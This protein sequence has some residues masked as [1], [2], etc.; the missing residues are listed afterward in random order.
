MIYGSRNPAIS[1]KKIHKTEISETNLTAFYLLHI[2][3]TQTY[4][5]PRSPNAI[6][7]A[8][9]LD[10]EHWVA[11]TLPFDAEQGCLSAVKMGCRWTRTFHCR[12]TDFL[13][14]CNTVPILLHVFSEQIEHAFNFV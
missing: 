12:P 1:L 7:F 14:R 2:R 3:K 13:K 4:R 11:L 5:A 8:S 6:S 10:G 9:H